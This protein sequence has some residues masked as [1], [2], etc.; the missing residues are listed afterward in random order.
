MQ[1]PP[2]LYEMEFQDYYE[3]LNVQDKDHILITGEKALF[4]ALYIAGKA[5]TDNKEVRARALI[6]KESKISSI[7]EALESEKEKYAEFYPTLKKGVVST[8]FGRHT[9]F[10]QSSTLRFNKI[11]LKKDAWDFK[12]FA[13][14][15]KKMYSI[16][17]DNLQITVKNGTDVFRKLEKKTRGM[18]R[19][20]TEMI[21]F[22]RYLKDC[23]L[24]LLSQDIKDN[25]SI[26]NA[27]LTLKLK[28]IPSNYTFLDKQ[29]WAENVIA[30]IG[31]IT[32]A[33]Q[34]E[35]F[36]IKKDDYYYIISMTPRTDN[37]AEF[38][39]RYFDWEVKETRIIS[40]IYAKNILIIALPAVQTIEKEIREKELI[41]VSPEKALELFRQR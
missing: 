10:E 36:V 6:P 3:A 32:L 1:K 8:S 15:L 25:D 20:K 23:G 38:T 11:F 16:S 40:E 7:S 30:E 27:Q 35:T 29:N 4:L 5:S 34:P 37:K 26:T 22:R 9:L 39:V 18:L 12:Q 2:L 21:T 31:Q 19:S 28:S 33:L 14:E 17:T 13:E 24:T 41:V